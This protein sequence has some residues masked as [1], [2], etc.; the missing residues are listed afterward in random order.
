M[1]IR[2]QLGLRPGMVVTFEMTKKGALLRKRSA[3]T[4]SVIVGEQV[5]AG[6]VECVERHSV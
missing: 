4:E 6:I 5:S 1:K 3:A 2:G